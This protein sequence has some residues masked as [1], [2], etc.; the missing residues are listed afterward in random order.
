[1]EFYPGALPRFEARG[2]KYNL[3]FPKQGYPYWDVTRGNGEP[4]RVDLSSPDAVFINALLK[5]FVHFFPFAP[6]PLTGEP[7]A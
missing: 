4:Q 5:E 6:E 2:S 7:I 3:Q 1:M